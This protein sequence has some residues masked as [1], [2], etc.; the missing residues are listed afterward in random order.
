MGITYVPSFVSLIVCSIIIPF[1]ILYLYVCRCYD[2][3]LIDVPVLVGR[4][5]RSFYQPAFFTKRRIQP[6]EELTWDYGTDFSREDPD[7]PYFE[8]KCGSPICRG[9]VD[10]GCVSL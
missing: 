10:I 1:M 7:L 4:L 2:A 5:D 9:H 6:L 8:C 3:N